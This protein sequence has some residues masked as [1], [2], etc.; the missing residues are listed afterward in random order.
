MKF[1]DND[2]DDDDDVDDVCEGKA[3]ML[4]LCSY[5][6]EFS[7]SFNCICFLK[8]FKKVLI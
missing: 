3:R 2:E 6:L 7:L 1:V 4:L 8:Q 5:C